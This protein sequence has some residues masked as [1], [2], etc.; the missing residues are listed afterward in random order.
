[1]GEK[2][3]FIYLGFDSD[4]VPDLYY[5][6][7]FTTVSLALGTGQQA[8]IWNI[9]MTLSIS[10]QCQCF[11]LS[12]Q[13]FM[14]IVWASQQYLLK[15]CSL[16]PPLTDAKYNSCFSLLDLV[17]AHK[18]EW[19]VCPIFWRNFPRFEWATYKT[20]KNTLG[21]SFIWIVFLLPS[22]LMN[23]LFQDR[24]S[25]WIFCSKGKNIYL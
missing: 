6:V 10:A 20:T 19:S 3:N 16:K 23:S 8:W 2:D 9:S 15:F 25:A 1:M 11:L 5:C 18:N 24:T 7:C 17:K 13:Y 22:Q 4:F 12:V 14:V 21:S